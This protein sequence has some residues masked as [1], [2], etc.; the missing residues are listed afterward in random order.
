[1]N[2]HGDTETQV[3][4]RN[5]TTHHNQ[6]AIAHG[7]PPYLKW[8]AYARFGEKVLESSLCDRGLLDL[9][10][11]TLHSANLAVQ[12]ACSDSAD[13]ESGAR[14]DPGPLLRLGGTHAAGAVARRR[15]LRFG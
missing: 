4:P 9:P 2:N 3:D 8:N 10:G 1:M 15:P 6:V 12:L 14:C 5:L 7:T 11:A 13:V